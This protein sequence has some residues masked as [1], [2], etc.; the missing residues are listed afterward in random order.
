VVKRRQPARSA[1]L[2]HAWPALSADHLTLAASSED[3]FDAACTAL[4]LSLTPPPD[5]ATDLTDAI[6]GRVMPVVCCAARPGY[7]TAMTD[8]PTD[9]QSLEQ[10]L[11]AMENRLKGLEEEL[12]AARAD[13]KKV[14]PNT[15]EP[16]FAE[17]GNV[18]PELTDDAIAPPG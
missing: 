12:A 10:R 5:V 8:G 1:H 15:D 14:L 13:A 18:H 4:T 11:A 9:P 17:S 6:E 3:A 2:R 16:T 7:R